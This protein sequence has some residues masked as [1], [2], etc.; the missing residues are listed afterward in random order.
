MTRDV[1]TSLALFLLNF[2]T[3]FFMIGHL[4]SKKKLLN[5][6]TNH[7]QSNNTNQIAVITS[8]SKTKQQKQME[9]AVLKQIWRNASAS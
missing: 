5:T 6:T 8:A 3:L 4:I 1:A 2:L 9:K 7:Q